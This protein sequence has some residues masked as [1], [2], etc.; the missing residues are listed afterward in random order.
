MLRLTRRFLATDP[1]DKVFALLGV[2]GNPDS[3]SVETDYRL[4]TQE[5]YLSVAIHN[6]EKLRDLELLANA[7]VG[8]ALEN[9]KLPSWVP[10]CEYCR[11]RLSYFRLSHDFIHDNV[12]TLPEYF[13]SHQLL[14]RL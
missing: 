4:S 3:I 7:G 11:E 8:S 9:P 5:V 13:F 6:L 14:T 10:D 2:V 1:R 12:P